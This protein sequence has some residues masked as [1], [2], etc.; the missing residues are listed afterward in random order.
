MPLAPALLWTAYGVFGSAG[1]L[2]YAVLSSAFARELAGRVNTAL[3]ALVFAW[4]F[5]VQWAIG[6]IIERWPVLD[7]R[8][9][10]DGYRAAFGVFLAVQ[11]FGF[12]WMLLDARRTAR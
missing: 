2:S 11:A 3:N 9:H 8:Y 6:G 7:G 1:S 12:A 4:A 10:A 5:V